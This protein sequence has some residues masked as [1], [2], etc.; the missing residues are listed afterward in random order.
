MA[1]HLDMVGCVGMSRDE[2]R[3]ERQQK[4]LI[5]RAY[6]AA[7][8]K[9]EAE[10]RILDR[11][12]QED[13]ERYFKLIPDRAHVAS[14]PL[15]ERSDWMK[16]A[17]MWYR[18]NIPMDDSD[19]EITLQV[20]RRDKE[21]GLEEIEALAG[22]L[23]MLSLMTPCGLSHI[24]IYIIVESSESRKFQTSWLQYSVYDVGCKEKAF[25]VPSEAWYTYMMWR[26]DS[27]TQR[28]ELDTRLLFIC[29]GDR[30]Q[31]GD[32]TLDQFRNFNADDCLVLIQ[33]LAVGQV[34]IRPTSQ[35]AG[36]S[37]EQ[38]GEIELL[39]I[40]PEALKDNLTDQLEKLHL[41]LVESDA[42][43]EDTP[44]ET[45]KDTG[46]KPKPKQQQA[47]KQPA[48][49]RLEDFVFTEEQHKALTDIVTRCVMPGS[50][51]ELT[52]NTPS[53]AWLYSKERAK[54]F[55]TKAKK[56]GRGKRMRGKKDQKEK[57]W[58]CDATKKIWADIHRKEAQSKAKEDSMKGEEDKEE[59][60]A[61]KQRTDEEGK[62]DCSGKSPTVSKASDEG[63]EAVGMDS[64]AP[65]EGGE[66][67][68]VL[69]E[70]VQ[71]AWVSKA[72]DEGGETQELKEVMKFITYIDDVGLIE[73]VP[74]EMSYLRKD[75]TKPQSRNGELNPVR[76][77]KDI[78]PDFT[79]DSDDDS[80]LEVIP[81]EE[82]L[83]DPEEEGEDDDGMKDISYLFNDSV[84]MMY[85]AQFD[86]EEALV[87]PPN[88]SQIVTLSSGSEDS[89]TAN[90][91]EDSRMLH[92][93]CE[94]CEA[95]SMDF[96]ADED[97]E[98][99]EDVFPKES[100]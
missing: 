69:C 1:H 40:D 97:T 33:S 86:V 98:M 11:I 21:T 17:G 64:K 72:S 51:D 14:Y 8:L 75:W 46:A 7:R 6:N 89:V 67:K 70:G 81:E 10:N 71:M 82:D 23:Y 12:L 15:E 85:M 18:F 37:M 2:M 45:P 13:D 19:P 79:L 65:D 88:E 20:W 74:G 4:L 25:T 94:S 93:S 68:K 63:G 31:L 36:L 100:E 43:P 56:S 66:S 22:D 28:R 29:I 26:E 16:E 38:G 87:K 34:Y 50:D 92:T 84:E 62:K 24:N 42:T 57:W 99:M 60:N 90:G 77:V 47:N 39:R 49:E 30:F 58:D 96:I 41:S 3:Q 27:P 95:T 5:K 53:K 59:R 32:I 61:K 48:V 73:T 91:P 78:I 55:S 83:S 9:A 35:E 54:F 52:N 80:S 76:E 44:P